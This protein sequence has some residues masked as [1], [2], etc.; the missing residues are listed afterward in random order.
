MTPLPIVEELQV[1]EEIGAR[2]GTRGPGSVVD[3][4]DLQRREEALGDGVVPA[5]APTAHAAH[6]SLLRQ[7]ALVGAA[8]VLAP[9]IRMMQQASRRAPA[10]QRHPERVAS[11]VVRD[12]FAQGPADDEARTESEDR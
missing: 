9:P 7:H 8:R 2:G 10:R 1:L 11:E 6:D 3:E 4:L 12:P 5:I